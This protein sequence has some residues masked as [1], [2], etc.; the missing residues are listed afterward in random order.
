[1][2]A[3]RPACVTLDVC[4]RF[5]APFTQRID[6]EPLTDASGVVRCLHLVSTV[7]VPKH[8]LAIGETPSQADAFADEEMDGEG[9]D[10]YASATTTSTRRTSPGQQV[11]P[12]HSAGA[13]HGGGGEGA[14]MLTDKNALLEAFLDF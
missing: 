7:V 10:G 1:M 6:L 11:S 9:S 5:G 14:S 13:G 8:D 4:S 2:V 12:Q 3:G